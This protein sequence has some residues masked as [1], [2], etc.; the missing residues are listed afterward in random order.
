M[1]NIKKYENMTV[2]EKWNILATVANLYYNSDMTQNEIAD[3]LYTSR[4]KISRMLK[5]AREL[6]IVE[7]S[8]KEPWER[9]L[10]LE[11][12]LMDHYKLKNVRVVANMGE[13]KEMITSRLSEVSSYYLDSIVRENMVVG[14]SW[15][16]TLF[17]IVKYIDK[18]NKKNIPITVVGSIQCKASGKRCY[19]SGK[20]SGFGIW[21][22]LSVYLCTIICEKQGI[23]RESDTGSD[24]QKYTGSCQKRRCDSDQCG[25][26][27][28]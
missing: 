12:Q 10:K 26:C 16:N 27:R 2:Q 3:R 17:H 18:N 15:G 25:F 5:E 14:I 4:S 9:D 6:G 23:K 19:G 28:I 21:R 11:G 20:G 1:D 7:I 22:K 8:I 13:S 24:N